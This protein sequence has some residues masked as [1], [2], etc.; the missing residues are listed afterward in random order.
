M[1]T[2]RHQNTP[3]SPA[4]APIRHERRLRDPEK[5]RQDQRSSLREPYRVRTPTQGPRGPQKLL[6]HG[7]N[8]IR[9]EKRAEN[10]PRAVQMDFVAY[11]AV[12]L[13]AESEKGDLNLF[14]PRCSRKISRGSKGGATP[15]RFRVGLSGWP[16]RAARGVAG[17]RGG[18][19]GR[20]R[21]STQTVGTGGIQE[22][23]RCAAH[24]HADAARPETARKPGGNRP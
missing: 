6:K 20:G 17:A 9:A 5:T 10:D 12:K 21:K 15:L 14:A 24:T 8:R 19:A 18:S 3:N 11:D 13:G 4:K 23:R 16:G 22:L 2:G 7:K 1:L